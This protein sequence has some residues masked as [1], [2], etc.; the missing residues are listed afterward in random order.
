MNYRVLKLRDTSRNRAA[1]CERCVLTPKNAT[2]C[3]DSYNSF[4]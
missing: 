4:G 3:F 2:G 1:I